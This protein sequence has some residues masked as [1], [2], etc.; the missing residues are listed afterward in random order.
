MEPQVNKI[1]SRLGKAKKTE[2]KSEKIEL[3]LVD[4]LKKQKKK[5]DSLGKKFDKAINN[6][7]NSLAIARRDYAPVQ[8]EFQDFVN[9]VEK[10]NQQGQKYISAIKE[11]GLDPKDQREYSENDYKA[12]LGMMKGSFE[13]A[14]KMMKG[15]SR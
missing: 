3:G 1:L 14:N 5:I 6:F 7:N 8:A 10:Y 11:L 13:Q 2:L 12:I 9:Q 4:D 15:I